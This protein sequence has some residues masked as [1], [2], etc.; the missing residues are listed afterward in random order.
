MAPELRNGEE[1]AFVCV[2]AW[3]ALEDVKI[4]SGLFSYIPG[5]HNLD[6]QSEPEISDRN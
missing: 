5:S 3:V 2:G 4:D 6:V 1:L